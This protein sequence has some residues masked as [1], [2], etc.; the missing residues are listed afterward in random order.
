MQVSYR[1]SGKVARLELPQQ[2]VF[3]SHVAFREA[4]KNIRAS[5]LVRA[6][7]IDFQRVRQ[8]DSAALG[9]LRC[10]IYDEPRYLVRL[11]NP[12]HEIRGMLEMAQL[13]PST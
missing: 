5:E 7:D 12:N 1:D 3:S 11:L 6:L 2:F 8:I 13:A 10:L 9:M 4:L